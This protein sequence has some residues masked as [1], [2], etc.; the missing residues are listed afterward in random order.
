MADHPDVAL[1][2][3]GYDAFQRGDMDTINEIFADDIEW[4]IP[5][6]SQLAGVRKG[7]AEVFDFLGQLMERSGGTFSLEVS[8]V[9]GNDDHVVAITR[10][11]A[12]DASKGFSVRGVH[13][14]TVKDGHAASFEGL[15]DDP[16]AEDDYWG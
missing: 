13:V 12:G 9:L 16:Y 4:T 1:I 2:R 8:D 10:E 11:S 7:K 14:W 15:T 6:R 5:G 3:R